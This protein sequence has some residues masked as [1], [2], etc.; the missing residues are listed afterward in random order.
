MPID[1]IHDDTFPPSFP[2]DTTTGDFENK[3]DN[4]DDGPKIFQG[5]LGSESQLNLSK[6]TTQMQ[7]FPIIQNQQDQIP[8][9]LPHIFTTSSINY[10]FNFQNQYP[11][12]QTNFNNGS[13]QLFPISTVQFQ[14]N[15][16]PPLLFHPQKTNNFL[17]MAQKGKKK[18]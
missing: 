10:N 8:Q 3:V 17:M 1:L 16:F 15:L 4:I 12:I 18:M 13:T 5:N 11:Y 14:P 9:Q 7:P 2:I 6:E